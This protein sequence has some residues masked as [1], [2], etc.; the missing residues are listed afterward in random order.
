M[1]G[2]KTGGHRNLGGNFMLSKFFVFFFR[3]PWSI[4]K[5]E[6]GE[7]KGKKKKGDNGREARSLKNWWRIL[8]FSLPLLTWTPCSI[9]IHLN[10]GLFQGFNVLGHIF[11]HSLLSVRPVRLLE[12]IQLFTRYQTMYIRVVRALGKNTIIP[13]PFINPYRFI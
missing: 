6:L 10:I 12:S 11:E 9:Q 2:L 5:E 8:H 7:Y 4:S 3:G 13:L 1:T